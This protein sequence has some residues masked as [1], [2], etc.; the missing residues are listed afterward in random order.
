MSI[1]KKSVRAVA[2][3]AIAQATQL[4]I[5]FTLLSVLTHLL[6]P[7]DFGLLAMTL[8][9]KNFLIIFGDFGLTAAV[10][11]KKNITDYQL[12]SIFWINV[13]V[14]LVLTLVLSSL[15][16]PIAAFYRESRLM[17]TTI[18]LS[19]VFLIISLGFV[20]NALLIKSLD[21]KRLAFIKITTL[22]FSGGLAIF[23]AYQGFGPWS[24]VFQIL[25]NQ[26]LETILLWTRSS[27]RPLFVFRWNEVRELVGFG[28]HLIG[29]SFINYFIRNFDDLLIGK[30]LGMQRL[31]FYNL[32]YRLLLFPLENL[33][34]VIAQVA[35]PAF[36]Q[37]QDDKK[38]ISEAYTKAARFIACMA[39]P[40]MMGLFIIAPEFIETF[41]GPQW[42]RS[43]FLVQI[44]SVA[45]LVESIGSLNGTIYKARGR[46]EIQFRMGLIFSILYF[47][48]FIIG[49]RWDIEGVAFGY[50]LTSL[51]VTYPSMIVVFKLIDLD[52]THFLR[53]LRNIFLASLF[54]SV[55]LFC[56]KYF[57]KN[58]MAID[59]V[60]LLALL[61][62]VGV[63]IYVPSLGW[64]DR[65]LYKE[66][67]QLI[68]VLK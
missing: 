54:M 65:N 48:A 53:Q 13:L 1:A 20:Q 61:F 3:V 12:S 11:Q 45:G 59:N 62:W 64:M 8:V 63:A 18:T 44:L 33:T 47:S 24:L 22:T 25:S 29:F 30:F 17:P 28:S 66:F 49:L 5:Q 68:R 58:A 52:F 39:F 67:F 6:T 21:F 41:L 15:A 23:L 31:G 7:N 26:F 56:V 42:Q 9:F 51:L 40:I 16:F 35:F 36:S 2:W 27:W 37:I 43:V 19:T 10:I 32:A 60:L 14:G 57:L 34:N 55:V 50:A 38:M 4:L 46:T